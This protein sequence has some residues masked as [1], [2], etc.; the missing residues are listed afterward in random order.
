MPA[1]S[2]CRPATGY[3]DL[4]EDIDVLAAQTPELHQVLQAGRVAGWSYVTLDDTLFA[5]DCCRTRNPDAGHDLW[6]SG[7]HKAHGGNVQVI[8]DP[9]GF[10]SPS[11]TCSR[12]QR[13]IPQ[14]AGH[15][16]VQVS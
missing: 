4:H 11:P 9:S 12:G 8:R 10:P 7:Q 16:S 13:M 5:T 6:Y 3:R 14:G 1:T 2:E 15:S